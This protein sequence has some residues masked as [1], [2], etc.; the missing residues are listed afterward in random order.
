MQAGDT[1]SFL[2]DAAPLFGLGLNDFAD[3]A[4]M[5]E[6]GRAGARRSIGEQDLDVA[7]ADLSSV[8]A[9]I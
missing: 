4:L 7:R 9:I 3:A 8:D 1:S 5:D 2:E 6:G